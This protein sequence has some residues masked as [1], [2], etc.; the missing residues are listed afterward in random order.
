[1]AT[2]ARGGERLD[3]IDRPLRIDH[4]IEP[5]QRQIVLLRAVDVAQEQFLVSVAAPVGLSAGNSVPLK[6]LWLPP[7]PTTM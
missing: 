4:R 7:K 5:G 6:S 2:G 1:M 3:W